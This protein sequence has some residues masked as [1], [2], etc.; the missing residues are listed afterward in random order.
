LTPLEVIVS[1]CVFKI[2]TLRNLRDKE[3]KNE[4]NFSTQ[5]S[6]SRENTWFSSSHEYESWSAGAE[7]P[8][9]QRPQ[10]TDSTSLLRSAA[11]LSFR[12]G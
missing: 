6:P 11:D 3:N 10:E 4:A 12:T 8:P 2:N 7:A 1:L 5:Q 9:C